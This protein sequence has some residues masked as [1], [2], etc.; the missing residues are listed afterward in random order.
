[1]LLR[2]IY[3]V[4]FNVIDSTN[5]YLKDNYYKLPNYTFVRTN[6][7]T[8]G[9]GQFQRVWE[10]NKNDNLLFSI[11]LKDMKIS[12]LYKIKELITEVLLSLLKKYNI[13]GTFVEP[14]DIYVDNDKILGILIETKV[15]LNLL[16]YIVIGIGVNVNQTSFNVLNSTSM[17]Q[18]RKK[19]IS[20]NKLY[21][22]FI[23]KFCIKYTDHI[24]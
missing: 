17:K 2:N 1:M 14:N 15:E 11:L 20:I 3:L 16:K 23:K 12:S 19:K 9:R 6:Y 13:N 5:N 18:L 22:D 8:S 7:Q 21:N 4:D 24:D 10:S